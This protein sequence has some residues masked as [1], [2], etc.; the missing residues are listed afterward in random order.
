M[1]TD[2][3]TDYF[4]P[5][6]CAR[7]NN[8]NTLLGSE[9]GMY[10]KAEGPHTL[11]INFATVFYTLATTVLFLNSAQILCLNFR[12]KYSTFQL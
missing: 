6:A 9:L 2:R 7:G 5:C 10:N 11:V 12:G 4:T 3:Q 8:N 1:T